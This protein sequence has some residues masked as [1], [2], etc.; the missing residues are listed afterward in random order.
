MSMP[1]TTVRSCLF[2]VILVCPWNLSAEETGQ[3]EE[4][5]V[6]RKVE[7]ITFFPGEPMHET[8]RRIA[9]ASGLPFGIEAIAVS[10][11]ALG[12]VT[13]WEHRQNASVSSLLDFLVSKYPGYGW[14]RERG[15]VH[16]RPEKQFLGSKWPPG[17][18]VGKAVSKRGGPIQEVLTGLWRDNCAAEHPDAQFRPV[19]VSR[20]PTI[21]KELAPRDASFRQVCDQIARNHD[22]VWLWAADK[23]ESGHFSHTLRFFPIRDEA[24][25]PTEKY[26]KLL[27]LV[28]GPDKPAA[29]QALSV[30]VIYGLNCHRSLAYDIGAVMADALDWRVEGADL[31]AVV[32]NVQWYLRHTDP[33]SP[34]YERSSYLRKLTAIASDKQRGPEL[35]SEAI[36]ALGLM[37]AIEA[38]PLLLE[39]KAASPELETSVD[40]SLRF[41]RVQALRDRTQRFDGYVKLIEELCA[42]KPFTDREHLLG[43]WSGRCISSIW[44]MLRIAPKDRDQAIDRL[45]SAHSSAK[46]SEGAKYAAGALRSLGV[47]VSD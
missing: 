1:T 5:A 13:E 40:F 8:A 7:S 24:L 46:T 37:A 25:G 2:L 35:R 20:W 33:H 12:G 30:F 15:V 42:K 16:I 41:L 4:Q 19:W 28:Q 44:V 6:A 29:T 10:D 45:K 17:I 38:V 14:S 27:K 18:E 43:D 3:G 31:L 11:R 21:L 36:E 26:E 34:P 32:A 22:V 23:Q 9:K 47:P 39:I